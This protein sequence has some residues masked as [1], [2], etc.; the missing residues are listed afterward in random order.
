MLISIKTEERNIL[1]C[2]GV[3]CSLNVR[4][5]DVCIN[6]NNTIKCNQKGQDV[7]NTGQGIESSISRISAEIGAM[8]SGIIDTLGGSFIVFF[9]SEVCRKYRVRA[10]RKIFDLP[11]RIA[12][13]PDCSAY[14]G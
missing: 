1:P 11:T 10:S 7:I 4:S 9:L 13:R 14:E 2:R 5:F 3:V 8:L 6:V 12:D